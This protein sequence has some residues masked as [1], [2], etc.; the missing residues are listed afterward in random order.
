MAADHDRDASA[1]DPRILRHIH[2]KATAFR[3][4]EQR[5]EYEKRTL[6]LRFR[7]GH[8]NNVIIP[9]QL[10]TTFLVRARP[11]S[12]LSRRRHEPVRPV[13]SRRNMDLR[14]LC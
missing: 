8:A 3:L 13:Q 10:Q 11:S 12:C 14:V 2:F 5:L 1:P 7:Y 9:A 6:K 4:H